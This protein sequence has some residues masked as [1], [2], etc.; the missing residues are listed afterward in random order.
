MP[1]AK[2]KI[3][4]LLADDHPVVR[5]GLRSCLA[6][7]RHLVIVGEASNGEQAVAL[8]KKLAPDIVLMD[9]NMPRLNGLE[10]TKLLRQAAPQTRVLILTVHNKRQFVLQIV[11]CGAH[12]YL[13]KE[14]SPAELVRAIETVARGEAYFSSDAA[15]FLL[16]G[17]VAVTGRPKSA[18]V[19]GMLTPREREVLTGI[20]SGRANKEIA[21]QLGVTV[22]TV[23]THRENVMSKLNI[24]TVAGLTRHAIAKGLVDLE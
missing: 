19:T 10:A 2:K 22:R 5:E 21:A 1:T 8:T 13:L 17:K 9:I 6:A 12:G 3:R 14:A 24:H 20:G 11:N 16:D 7:H 4:V 23:E 15:R 18:A